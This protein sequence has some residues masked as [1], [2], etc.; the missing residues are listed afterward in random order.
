MNVDFVMAFEN[1]ELSEDGI[2]RGFQEGSH[3]RM[4]RDLIK[5]GLCSLPEIQ[6][7]GE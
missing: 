4:A 1:G 3:S 2:I 6:H 7:K 5:S